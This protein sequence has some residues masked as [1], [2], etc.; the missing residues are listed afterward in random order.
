V[1]LS[2]ANSGQCKTIAEEGH[3]VSSS[4]W[5]PSVSK[6]DSEAKRDKEKSQEYKKKEAREETP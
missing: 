1:L 6:R 4:V 2:G 5:A 3:L